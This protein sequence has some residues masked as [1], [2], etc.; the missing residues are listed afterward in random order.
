MLILGALYQTAARED[1]FYPCS[2][3]PPHSLVKHAAACE[4]H[5]HLKSERSLEGFLDGVE[6]AMLVK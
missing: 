2:M 6:Q 3:Q 5:T 4:R 1:A